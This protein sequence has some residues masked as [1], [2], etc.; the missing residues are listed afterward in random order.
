MIKG[1]IIGTILCILVMVGGLLYDQHQSR[2]ERLQLK[3][4]AH[5]LDTWQ[6]ADAEER[7]SLAELQKEDEARIKLDLKHQKELSEKIAKLET[8]SR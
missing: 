3:V 4:L 2:E 8:D 5:K 1:L 7:R 6:K